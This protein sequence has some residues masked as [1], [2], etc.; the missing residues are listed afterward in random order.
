MSVI[1]TDLCEN[2]L[3]V[4]TSSW[5]NICNKGCIVESVPFIMALSIGA[6]LCRKLASARTFHDI[7]CDQEHEK[8]DAVSG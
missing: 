6:L 1:D 4:F 7:C 3:C 2:E 5:L 8:R